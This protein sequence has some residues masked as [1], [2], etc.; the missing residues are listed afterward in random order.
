MWQAKMTAAYTSMMPPWKRA[1]VPLEALSITRHTRPAMTPDEMQRLLESN[2][3]GFTAKEIPYGRQFRLSD[4]AIA[5]VY[6][7]GKVVWQ[8]K[9]SRFPLVQDGNAPPAEANQEH[10]KL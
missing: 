4:G 9:E 1:R 6:D 8:G 5:N 7:K 3:I 10:A 2:N